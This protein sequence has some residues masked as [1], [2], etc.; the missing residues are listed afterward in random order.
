MPRRKQPKRVASPQ[1]P[2][3]PTPPALASANGSEALRKERL[4]VA[5][6]EVGLALEKFGKHWGTGNGQF[7]LAREELRDATNN[8]KAVLPNE[9]SSPTPRQ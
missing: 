9:S 7:W 4:N 1:V 3:L 8:L 2:E 6:D 5:L